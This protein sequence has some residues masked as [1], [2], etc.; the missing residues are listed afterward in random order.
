NFESSD[1]VIAALTQNGVTNLYGP[2]LTVSDDKLDEGKSKAR[3][4]AVD[5]AHQKAEQLAKLS[6]R[7][8]GKAV[9]LTEQGNSGHPV[10]IMASDEADL[11]EK[12]SLIQPG[13]NEVSIN[14]SVDFA[15]K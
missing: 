5:N 8:L 4:K 1:E 9:K 10:P 2:N 6:N 15:L 14:L 12:A 11:K 7:K 3:E 13:T